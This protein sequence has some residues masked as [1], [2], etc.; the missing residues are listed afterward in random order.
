M[1]SILDKLTSKN[2]Q[3]FLK[4]EKSINKFIPYTGVYNGE[5]VLTNNSEFVM[6]WKVGGR[7][8]ET[9]DNED[10]NLRNQQLNTFMRNLTSSHT[11]IYI[12][13]THLFNNEHFESDFNSQFGNA[14][15]ERYYSVLEQEK[16]T[17]TDLYVSLVYRIYATRPE[18]AAVRVAKRSIAQIAQD[19]ESAYVLMKEYAEKIESSLK[20]YEPK[21]LTSYIDDKGIEYNEQL[22]FLNFLITF[23]WQKIRVPKNDDIPIMLNN[24]LGNCSI[25][26][27]DRMLEI[28]SP[29]SKK[30]AQSIEIKEYNSF[31]EVGMLDELLYPDSPPYEFIECQSFAF[32]SLADAKKYLTIQ[33]NQLRSAEDGAVSQGRALDQALDELIDGQ[34]SIGE[35]CYSLIV[36]GQTVEEAKK[37]TQT[38]ASI[39]QNLGFIPFLSKGTII[40]NWLSLLPANFRYRPRI[41]NLTS[42][43]FVQLA[44]LNNLPRGKETGNPWGKAVMPFKTMSN[45]LVFFNFH[46]SP[47][48]QNNYDDKLLGNTMIIGKS[49]SGKTV[50]LTAFLSFLQ[51]YRKDNNGQKIKFNALYFDKDRGAEIAI[52]A[53][54]GGYLTVNSGKPSGFNPFQMENTP[55]NRVFLKNLICLLLSQTGEK[56]TT[57]D[58][59]KIE[60]AVKTVM[61]MPKPMRRLSTI[62]QNITVGSTREEK[63]N[64]IENR[65]KQ[66]VHGGIYSWVFDDN[67]Q[68]LLDLEKYTV[69]GI[70]GTTFLDDKQACAPISMYLLHRMDQIIDGRRFVYFMDEFWKWLE[71]PVFSEF[72]KNKQLTIRKQ[73]GFG[74]FATQQ[75]D[76]IVDNPNAS[77][78]VGQ[79]ATMIFL[80][81]PT[82]KYK[83]YKGFNIL[84]SEFETIKSLNEDSREFLVKQTGYDCNGNIRSYLAMFD[85][86]HPC[87]KDD[88]KILSG[89]T[90][91]IPFLE[92]AMTECGTNP[93]M[94]IPRFLELKK[95]SLKP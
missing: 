34:F 50:L 44:P 25:K 8:F 54:N 43:N 58:N 11:A 66:W 52:R 53:L 45:Q 30:F 42:R 1:I 69:F 95:T 64:S 16:L 75:P 61:G 29:C 47:I 33:Q 85:L 12:H 57:V 9:T 28:D 84:D 78:L 32:K 40:G 26:V 37:N 71:D 10:L 59:L 76:I 63:E 80:P 23:Q 2:F 87:F 67:P 14:F 22:S 88:L 36:L 60:H 41:S 73:N 46:D 5:C 74:V 27:G 6:T 48:Y 62:L 49:G 82:A 24:Y 51:Q 86:S 89:S 20:R 21:L 83:D 92:Q 3:N 56:V 4:R 7:Y 81:N 31:T 17:R 39:L 91:N 38:T 90:D 65:L 68:D 55:E 94:W 79:L 35:Y 72:C 77:A 13:R 15:A 93:D 70:D 19:V 18:K